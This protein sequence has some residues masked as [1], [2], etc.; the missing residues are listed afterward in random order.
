MV[1]IK[2]ELFLGAIHSASERNDDEPVT[3]MAM[4]A[5]FHPMVGELTLEVQASGWPHD[6]PFLRSFDSG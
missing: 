2:F 3:E 1:N 5:Q 6:C 4:M